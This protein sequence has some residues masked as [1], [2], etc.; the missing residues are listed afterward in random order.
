MYTWIL[1]AFSA[2]SLFFYLFLFGHVCIIIQL[3]KSKGSCKTKVSKW[4]SLLFRSRALY[5]NDSH[6]YLIVVFF[7]TNCSSI[8]FIYIKLLGSYSVLQ[9]DKWMRWS[10]FVPWNDEVC[11]SYG[12]QLQN[13]RV[14][15]SGWFS[16]ISFFTHKMQTYMGMSNQKGTLDK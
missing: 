9:G 4:F 5:Q 3:G 7:S 6:T 13:S 8:F 12:E 14:A 16:S 15:A 10:S 2:L 11:W 1:L